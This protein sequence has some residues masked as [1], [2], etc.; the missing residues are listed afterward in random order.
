MMSNFPEEWL[1]ELL[2]KTDIV[3]VASDYTALSPKGGRFWGCCPLHN[4]KTP[5]FSVQSE[6][7]MFYCFGCH[8]GG[9]VINLVMKVEKVS[10]SEAVTMLAQRAGMELPDEIND[11]KL[12][13]ERAYKD[14]LYAVCKAAARFYH[15]KLKSDAGEQAR[16]YLK[17][18]GV[19]WET[20]VRF[21]LGFAPDSW[22]EVSGYL[23][24]KGFTDREL[25]DAGVAIR[26]KAGD[27][28]YDAYRGRLIYP[29]I[30]TNGRV[31]GFG[32]RTLKKDEQPKYINTGDTPI[33][34]KRNNLYA[35]NMQKGLKG[36]LIMVEGYM[37]VISLHAAGISNAVASLGTAMTQSQAR[38]VK[39]FTDKVFLC[40]DGDSAGQNA[41]LRGIDILGHEG[42]DVRVI[43]IPDDLDP[44]DY[45][46]KYG[47]N[48]FL[49][50]R[51]TAMTGNGFRLA[52]MAESFDLMSENGREAFAV[53][54]CAFIGTLQ[55]VEKDRYI[56]FVARKTGIPEDTIRAQCGVAAG[57]TE[58]TVGKIRNTRS[59]RDAEMLPETD[60]TE[61]TL[62]A[63]M[64]GSA[65][66]AAHVS[67][68][69]AAENVAFTNPGL[70]EFAEAILL[71]Y[72][73]GNASPDMPSL[74]AGL[75]D[76]DAAA[77]VFADDSIA[78]NAETVAD[79]CIKTLVRRE[80]EQRIKELT[81]EYNNSKNMEMIEQ[82]NKLQIKL[83]RYK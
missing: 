1:N 17:K 42:L 27:G 41:T 21:G 55:P 19:E 23:K 53:K 58:N 78:D 37:D 76:P 71:A 63:C 18:R 81:D 75:K 46:R 5:S 73:G 60:K 29:I 16:K 39:R 31:L 49:K 56:P 24:K 45:V 43:K 20:V 54:A 48:A 28:C 79:D 25:I 74:I 69:M 15:E 65:E 72:A 82:I 8:A 62:A 40:Y 44:D 11:E 67:A 30:A 26:N 66:A 10:F 14:K 13:A 9:G 52:N 3:S 50:L 64:L 70:A 4:E 77:S 68:R 36:E 22:D 57:A 61:R 6:K 33:Y 35:M 80:I 83:T 51:D 32:A 38:L 2:A 7:Q 12:R 59:R 47:K 34:N